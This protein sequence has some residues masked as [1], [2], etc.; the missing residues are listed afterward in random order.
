MTTAEIQQVAT[1]FGMTVA[2]VNSAIEATATDPCKKWKD[3]FIAAAA[4]W[5]DCEIRNTP[6]SEPETYETDPILGDSP[7]A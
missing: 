2:E 5:L 4:L 6:P 1:R 3:G 7:K